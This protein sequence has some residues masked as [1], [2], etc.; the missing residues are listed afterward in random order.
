MSLY[1]PQ[2]ASSRCFC[3]AVSLEQTEKTNTEDTDEYLNKTVMCAV[4]K[5]AGCTCEHTLIKKTDQ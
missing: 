4:T 3:E 1:S 2:A 5:E